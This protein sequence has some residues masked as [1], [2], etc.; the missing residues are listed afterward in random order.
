MATNLDFALRI[1]ALAEGLEDVAAM[2]R[3]LEGLVD[4]GSTQIP[5]NT[6]D[7]R[8]G[9]RAAA[10][11]L[12]GTSA[13]AD[14]VGASL[15]DVDALAADIDSV[16]LE[17]FTRELERMAA[18]GGELGPRFAEAAREL[19]ALQG[20]AE[21]GAT[22]V[23]QLGADAQQARTGV[24]GI[25]SAAEGL[26]P[27]L[28]A[29]AKAV[30]GVFAISKLKGYAADVI[31]VADAYGQMAS[32][33]EIATESAEEY[34]LVQ[35][36][37]LET[38]SAT[39]RP[40]AEA[41]E[42]YIQT[43]GSLRSLG[44]ATSDALD[45]TD[46]FSYLLVSNAASA[47]A[48]ASS[49]KAY[50]KALQAGRLDAQGWMSIVTAMPTVVDSIAQATGRSAE[51]IRNL[52][53]T[54]K[55]AIADLNEGL[56][57]TVEANKAVA[58]SMPTTVA[59]AVQ[60][61]SNSWSAYVGEAN[62]AHATTE[63]IVEL[64]ELVEANLEGLVRAARMAGEV[65]L[66]AFA[67]RAVTGMRTMMAAAAGAARSVDAVAVATGRQGAAAAAATPAVRG[68]AAATQAHG[69]AAAA[70][71]AALGRHA[72]AATITGRAMAALGRT[73][74]LLGW[75]AVVDQVG[76]V[77]AAYAKL[78]AARA[79]LARS[80]AD[81]D[82]SAARLAA[83]YA[84]LS[85]Q[86]G[87]AISSVEDFNEAQAAGLIV[88]DEAQQRWVAAAR[89]LDGV[90]VSAEFAAA[91][92]R[93]VNAQAMIDQ[94]REIVDEGKSVEEALA[95]ISQAVDLRGDDALATFAQA[96]RDLGETGEASARQTADAWR[97]AIASLDAGELGDAAFRLREAFDSGAISAREFAE[98]ND[99][100]LSASF[101]RLGIN[102]AAALGKISPAAADAI[103]AVDSIVGALGNAGVESQRAALVIEQSLA[104]AFDV[105]D[106][107]PAL[108]AL[109][110]RLKRLAAEG[111]LSAQGV[112]RLGEEVQK[113][114]ARIEQATPGVT[115]VT[116]ALERNAAEAEAAAKKMAELREEYERLMQA[117]DMQ[118]AAAVQQQMSELRQETEKTNETLKDTGDSGNDAKDGLENA[119]EGAKKAADEADEAEQATEKLGKS[120]NDTTM[121]ARLYAAQIKQLKADIAG[122]SGAALRAVEAAYDSAAGFSDAARRIQSLTANAQELIAEDAMGG[123]DQVFAEAKD[124][125]AALR[126]ELEEMQSFERIF[127][128]G[129][130]FAGLRRYIAS[131]QEMKVALAEAKA[132]LAELDVEVAAFD[133]T[134]AA[135]TL[136]LSEQ[137]R[138]LA[139][140][141]ARAEELGSQQLTGLR[142]AL[143]DVRRKMQDVA[144]SARDTLGQLQDELDEIEGRYVAI[145]RR[146]I[147]ARRADI[148]AQLAEARA[149]GDQEAVKLLT[150][151]LRALEQ[152]EKAR[153]DEAKARER[154]TRERRREETS[155][156]ARPGGGEP[157]PGGRGTTSV[158]SH[159]PIH[160]HGITDPV[161]LAPMLEAE[162]RKLA[163][164]R[165]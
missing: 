40:L 59:D 160:I 2:T 17:A 41:Q 10:D 33:I 92:L 16:G 30:A 116:Q 122:Y 8:E 149:S 80:E 11:A 63:L 138:E 78:R 102:A 26:Q 20:S 114:R 48:A 123:V 42:L 124:E 23:R 49:I 144:E 97:V 125:A 99:Q 90:T 108:D 3:E 161:K 4:A 67:M 95:A 109:E 132:R 87:L 21:G 112:A 83:R 37:L 107:L 130:A 12:Q 71:T 98:V 159:M 126:A 45:V 164:L 27:K 127:G 31:D 44:L 24:D 43:A 145:E 110:A 69:A 75:L 163:K 117:G 56:R 29:L 28:N 153:L 85:E 22:S 141:V 9:A 77:V 66:A 162:L 135:G 151:A 51:E 58:D 15:R 143:D 119:A 46:S 68:V 128:A 50:S 152:I 65:M 55:L 157:G 136:S 105:A 53:A 88:Y 113:A 115:R 120:I 73:I 79:E 57:R 106:S 147:A 54:G 121:I 5:D 19:R 165:N 155:G 52:G 93:S 100:I 36:R 96:L 14:D 34:E 47:D 154:E 6:G 134:V 133:E 137:E 64:V 38:A 61:L 118:G 146:R 150:E 104:R 25:G 142:A 129:L 70:A 1:R 39:Y 81:A 35:R 103:A 60:A 74:R 18:E 139:R 148:Q 94:F 89:T 101:E 158:T 13:A 76:S 62:R 91:A 7:L 32:R 156:A 84:E 82:A 131:L 86:T 111:K 72:A 140:L